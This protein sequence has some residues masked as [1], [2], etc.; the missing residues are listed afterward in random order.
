MGLLRQAKGNL[1]G[2]SLQLLLPVLARGSDKNIVRLTKLMEKVAIQPGHKEQMRS[3]RRLCEEK[4]PALELVRRVL[5]ETHPNCRR[6]LIG[7][8]GVNAVYLTWEKRNERLKKGL[9]APFLVVISPSMRCNL[10]CY[11]CYAG[12][13]TKDDD[14]PIELVDKIVTEAKEIGACFFTI[15]GGEPFVREDMLDIY[16]KHS[17]CNF[18]I[19][20]NGTLI[21]KALAHK[22]AELGNVGPCISL[23]GF[24]EKTDDRR[25]SGVFDLVLAAMDNL[26]EAGVIHGFSGTITR[27]NV[28]EITSDELID[29]L[30]EKGCTLGWYFLYIPIGKAP[31]TSLMPTPE[32]RQYSRRRVN[33]I[34]NSKPIFVADFWN[35]GQLTHGC[36]AG[37]RLYLHVNNKGDIEPCVFSHFSVDNVRDKT[38]GEALESPFFKAIRKRFPWTHNELKPCMIIDNP[39]VL[40]EAVREGGAVPSHEGAD[41]IICGLARQLDR[42]A[43]EMEHVTAPLWEEI[44]GRK[45]ERAEERA[46]EDTEKELARVK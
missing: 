39:K 3:L 22:L 32:Q 37:G 27:H 33:E 10:N 7:N 13:Y 42:Y 25:G 43:D 15:S 9:A 31:D 5:T 40:R 17:D 19:Y 45:G 2:Q 30:I 38:I 23:E 34:R 6:K 20:T 14:L 21:D 46:A 29:L 24:G 26:K 35:D 12:E 44:T 11:G 18:L 16:K 28:E 41:G 4:H 1:L 8:L 36:M